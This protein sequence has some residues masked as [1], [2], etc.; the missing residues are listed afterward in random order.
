VWRSPPPLPKKG[1]KLRLDQHQAKVRL[2]VVKDRHETLERDLNIL[3][4]PE[5][6]LLV[7][8][9]ARTRR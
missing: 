9:V 5:S 2:H 1:P 8:G 3:L 6:L 7:T 4:D